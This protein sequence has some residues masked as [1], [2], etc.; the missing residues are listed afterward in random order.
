MLLLERIHNGA[1]YVMDNVKMLIF[2]WSDDYSRIDK[3]PSSWLFLL[4]LQIPTRGDKHEFF[5]M[6]FVNEKL[7]IKDNVAKNFVQECVKEVF[8]LFFDFME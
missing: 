8:F 3:M 6:V 7:I 4:L 1:G 5:T 2:C